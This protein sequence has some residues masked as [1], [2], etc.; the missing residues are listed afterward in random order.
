M[1]I[2]ELEA[3]SGRKWVWFFS[4]DGEAL[5]DYQHSQSFFAST[6]IYRIGRNTEA[7]P[8][9][10]AAKLGDCS[11]VGYTHYPCLSAR[12]K[13]VLSSH[14]DGLGQW[15]ELQCDEAPYWL[16]NVTHTVNALDEAHSEIA[17]FRDG[18]VMGIDSFAFIPEKL[19][20]ALMFTVPQCPGTPILATQD[21]V[22][23]I[24]QHSLTGFS[25]R[26]LWS[27]ENGPVSSKLKDWERPRITGLESRVS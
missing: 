8:M 15:L 7:T 21:F 23:L 3:A 10:S 25:F 16:F 24:H 13:A 4:L 6:P 14:V 11:N 5:P 1:N 20:G 9:S 26:L 17:R 27:E 19:R 12:A 22:D 2:Y 18:R